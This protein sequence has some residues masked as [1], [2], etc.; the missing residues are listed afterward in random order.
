[1][2]PPT[3]PMAIAAPGETKAQGAVMATNPAK[4][5][6]IAME[7]SG[8]PNL[9]QTTAMATIAPAA[10]AK[11]VLM[12]IRAIRFPLPTLRAEPG[13]NPNQ[14]NQRMRTPREAKGMECPFITLGKPFR[15]YLPILGPRITVPIKAAEP[16]VT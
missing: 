8:F 9:I 6:F 13:L 3:A 16:P 5:P 15:A 11:L 1:M 7:R 10:A 14:P 12:A 4:A 2:T